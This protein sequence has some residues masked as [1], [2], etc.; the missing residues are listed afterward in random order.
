MRKLNLTK[1]LKKNII[2]QS[3]YESKIKELDKAIYEDRL[4][5]SLA[6]IEDQKKNNNSFFVDQEIAGYERIKAYLYEYYQNGVIDYL[7]YAE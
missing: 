2:T 3:E 4:Q 6:W 7:E 5:N 1:A